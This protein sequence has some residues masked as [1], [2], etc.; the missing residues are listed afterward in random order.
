MKSGRYENV[1]AFVKSWNDE[2]K[3]RFAQI[4]VGEFEPF[5]RYD[6]KTHLM[7]FI[8]SPITGVRSKSG[9]SWADFEYDIIEAGFPR[10][11]ADLLGMTSPPRPFK[12]LPPHHLM[13]VYSD[14]VSPYLVGDVQTS[15]LR[16][17]EMNSD[18]LE[19]VSTK[20][21]NPYYLPVARRNFDT[22]EI[23]INS[24]LG[25]PIPFAGGK[26]VAILHFKRCDGPVLSKSSLG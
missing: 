23:N 12:L 17:V 26:S 15:L 16:V 24:E 20:F 13:Y 2:L 11:F 9:M 3:K 7:S 22:I 1:G 4:F 6:A 19:I 25:T 18:R 5:F 10:E 21:D 8:M 14:I